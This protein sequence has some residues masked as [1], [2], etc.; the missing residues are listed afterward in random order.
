MAVGL[1]VRY[2]L[3]KVARDRCSERGVENASFVVADAEALPI[4]TSS[5]DAVVSRCTLHHTSMSASLAE[6]RRVCV[7]GGKVFM[8]DAVNA[9][10]W[11]RSLLG[12]VLHVTFQ[13]ARRAGRGKFGAAGK[14]MKRWASPSWARHMLVENKKLTGEAFADVCE[15]TLPGA[16]IEELRAD[17]RNLRWTAPG[18]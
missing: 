13:V 14:F 3:V 16:R 10:A 9:A 17:R 4:K 7:P 6:I 2:G 12:Y 15:E 1:D 11:E 18:G 5:V 8:E